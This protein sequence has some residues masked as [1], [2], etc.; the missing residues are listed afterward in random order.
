MAETRA[1]GREDKRRAILAAAFEVFGRRGYADACVREVAE[2]AGVA[3]PTVYNHLT[4][5]ETLFRHA[6]DAVADQVLADGLAVVERLR[7]PGDDL[8][9]A[10]GDVVHRLVSAC[11]DER[12]RTLR[13]LVRAQAVKFPDLVESVHGR[14][15]GRLADALADRLARL[16]LDGRLRRCEPGVAAEQLLALITGPIEARSRAGT[17]VV[18]DEEAREVAENAVDTFLRAFGAAREG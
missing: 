15:S 8:R 11:C 1:R 14:T 2:V 13:W 7:E 9:A 6:V 5:K 18:P 16:V 12:S 10:L 4:D 3:K 17:R